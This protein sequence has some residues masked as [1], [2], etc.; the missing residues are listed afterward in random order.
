MILLVDTLL[1]D[2]TRSWESRFASGFDHFREQFTQAK[3][4]RHDM[5]PS[6]YW[7]RY[8]VW[9][10]VNSD[11][12]EAIRLRHEFFATKMRETLQPQSKDPQR[13]FGRLERE[14][15]YYRD[16]KRCAVCDAEVVWPE[17][18]I[19]H[20]EQHAQGGRTVLEN[21]ALVHRHCHPKGSAAD[22]FAKRWRHKMAGH[23]HDAPP[24]TVGMDDD[25]DEDAS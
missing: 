11:R 7:L 20:I 22:E 5:N 4:S 21:G 17:A 19:H 24:S 8:G 6:D 9:T 13:A 12:G 25:D 16:R 14:L 1:D 3:L 10:R 18:E 15:L 23:R 2:Y